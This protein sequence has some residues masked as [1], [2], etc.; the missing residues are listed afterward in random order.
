MVPFAAV[1]SGQWTIGPQNVQS[2]NGETSFEVLGA[3]AP[4]QSTGTALRI[5]AEDAAKLP[6][7][8]GL[9]WTG[10]SYE[11]QQAGSQTTALYTIS[12]IVIL[13]YLA[14]LYESW[15]IPLAVLLVIPLGLL[16]A[17]A[18]TLI[19]GLDNDVYFQVGLLT[20]V[21]LA[22]KNAILIVEF[23]KAFFEEGQSLRDAALNAARERL[24]PILMTSLAFVLGV[25]PL[26]VA[27][28]AGA[29]SRIA[30][31]TAV[32]GGMM[33]STVLAVFYVPVFF[34]VV[35][36]LFRVRPRPRARAGDE[37]AI[38]SEAVS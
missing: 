4:G 34:V 1:L 18:G 32:V 22:V 16:G 24:R 26:A 10:L 20:T 35:L 28:G 7:G 2:F 30:I 23:A 12:A 8:V 37:D 21:G 3:P 5:L 14:A 33:T 13:L 9:E 15:A 29:S 25:L 19:R 17:V 11:Q 31:G 36:R 27:S 38:R 6:Q